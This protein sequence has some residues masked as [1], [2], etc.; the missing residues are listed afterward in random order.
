MKKLINLS[1]LL[2]VSA[3]LFLVPAC[4]ER[5][6]DKAVGLAE[7]SISLDEAGITKSGDTTS[8]PGAAYHLL[9]SVENRLGEEVLTDKMIPV[10]LF[11]TGFVSEKV[12][13]P[14]GEMKLT[15]FMVINASG[16]V[17]YATPV[18]GSPL[19]YLAKKPLPVPFVV[20]AG[21]TVRVVPEVLAVENSDPAQFGYVNFG[22]QIIKPLTFYTCAVLESVTA[23]SVIQM[24]GAK[25]TVYDNTGWHY[26]FRLEPVVNRIV[27]RGGSSYYT[28]LAEKEGYMPVRIQVPAGRL[29]ETTR[30]N[31]FIIRFPNNPANLFSMVFQPGP[32]EAKDAMISN[33]EP[34]K[35]FGG[36]PYFEATYRSEPVLTVMRENRSL[37]FF[38]L[39][40]LPKS[41]II[42]KVVLRLS[43][44]LPVPWPNFTPV[45]ATPGTDL[46]YGA[47]LQQITTPWE[48]FKVTWNSQPES[49]TANQV[50]I[51][52]LITNTNILDV[53]VTRL[54]VNELDVQNHGML[55]RQW[56]RESFPGFRFASGDHQNAQLRPRLTVYY[57]LPQ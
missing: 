34:D 4:N 28:L 50:Y 11:G 1:G 7:F 35:N 13:I 47:V 29:L 41:A 31:P 8:V 15:K 33:L 17:V 52:P 56:P 42:K 39:G 3:A 53:D 20:Q 43:F 5:V 36:H 25:L 22:I 14:A 45:T 16:A 51:T 44:D 37:I 21:A 26:S 49:T 38:N 27:V 57:T 48:E 55:F 2:L 18:A 46:W 6:D 54:F 12:E 19:A 24:T 23:T 30:E 40:R 32:E 10:Y 9:V